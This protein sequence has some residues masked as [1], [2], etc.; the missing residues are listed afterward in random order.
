[1][2]LAQTVTSPCAVSQDAKR[3]RGTCGDEAVVLDGERALT[4]APWYPARAG[5]RITVHYEAT[6]TTTAFKGTY[7]VTEVPGSHR[8]QTELVL[9]GCDPDEPEIRRMCG[10]YAGPGMTDPVRQLWMQAGPARLVIERYDLTL[11]NG[12]ASC[13]R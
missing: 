5:D 11:H 2:T 10:L 1:M 12:P 3:G 8:D 4:S 9:T 13:Q 6:G 7:L